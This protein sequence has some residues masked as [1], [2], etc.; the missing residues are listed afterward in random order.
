[1]AEK[2]TNLFFQLAIQVNL[3]KMPTADPDI[4]H[5]CLFLLYEFPPIGAV[6]YIKSKSG[7]IAGYNLKLLIVY[8][9]GSQLEEIYSYAGSKT[10]LA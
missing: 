2:I 1:L 7:L 9:V 3:E 6:D 8:Q 4:K 10:L 5:D